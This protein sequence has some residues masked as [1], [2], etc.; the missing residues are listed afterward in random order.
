VANIKSSKKDVRR[1]KRRNALN[2]QQRSR[3][4]TYDK[5][6]RRLVGEGNLTEARSQFSVYSGLLDRAGR[7][8]LIHASQADRRKSRMAQLLNRSGPA[9]TEAPAAVVEPTPPPAQPE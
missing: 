6:I 9:Q 8:H 1:I 4:R 7:R 2:V 3:L 5:K